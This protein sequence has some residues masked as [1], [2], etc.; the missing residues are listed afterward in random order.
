M[1]SGQIQEAWDRISRWYRQATGRQA[2]PYMKGLDQVT[3]ERAELYRCRLLEGL[4][5]PL[6]V[7]PAEVDD[8]I[9]SEAEIDSEMRGLK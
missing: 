2:P 4:C 9:T 3:M 7:G 1:E 8:G 6:L 5:L